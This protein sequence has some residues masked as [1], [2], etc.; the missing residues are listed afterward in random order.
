MSDEN[1]EA[2]RRGFEAANRRHVQAPAAKP[3]RRDRRAALG[4]PQAFE[5]GP[6][7][8]L[9]LL[10]QDRLVFEPQHERVKPRN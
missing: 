3:V 10:V 1:A 9:A 6:N 7:L 5:R 8:L 2:F 4:N